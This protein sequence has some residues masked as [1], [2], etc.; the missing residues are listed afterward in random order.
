MTNSGVSKLRNRAKIERRNFANDTYL[1]NT[2]NCILRTSS[3]SFT[4]QM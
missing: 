2:V 1:L 4:E 3:I